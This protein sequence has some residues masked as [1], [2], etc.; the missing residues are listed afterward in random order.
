MKKNLLLS[1]SL[2]GLFTLSKL[3]KS[4]YAQVTVDESKN[5]LVGS[6]SPTSGYKFTV[7]GNSDVLGTI[8]SNEFL[9]QNLFGSI[10]MRQR[11]LSNP[12]L[13]YQ[14]L[15]IR[16][17]QSQAG[18]ISLTE[19]AVADRWTLGILPNQSKFVFSQGNPS[20]INDHF[21][22][23]RA[24]GITSI[25]L[26]NNL[27]ISSDRTVKFGNGSGN[28]NFK[29]LNN[30]NQDI[31]TVIDNGRVHIDGKFG[32]NS[33][34][35][36]TS[37]FTVGGNFKLYSTQPESD[38]GTN[39]DGGLLIAFQ[40]STNQTP[41]TQ[42]PCTRLYFGNGTGYQ[43]HFSKRVNSTTTDLMTIADDGTIVAGLLKVRPNGKVGINYNFN[44]IVSNFNVYGHFRLGGTQDD[45]DIGQTVETEMLI[46]NKNYDKRIFFGDGSGY[47]INF[48]KR[49]NTTTTDLV[50]I[51]DGGHMSI[52]GKLGIGITNPAFKLDIHDNAGTGTDVA[53]GTWVR[54]NN[55]DDGASNIGLATQGI[56]MSSIKGVKTSANNYNGFGTG[57]LQMNAFNGINSPGR[58]TLTSQGRVSIGYAN[59]DNI[60][61]IGLPSAVH[62]DLGIEIKSLNNEYGGGGLTHSYISGSGFQELSLKGRTDGTKISSKIAL[63]T[64][65]WNSG[66]SPGSILFYTSTAGS[67]EPVQRM[68]I[69]KEGDVY[70]NGATNGIIMKSPNGTCFKITID[71]NGNFYPAPLANCP[72]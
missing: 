27:K 59:P 58:M 35:N 51:S 9:T 12:T 13:Y 36:Y 14:E 61:H 44:P 5:V 7:N 45:A 71:D 16:P 39:V 50:T 40:N 2:I 65:G 19:N 4:L 15:H 25:S 56:I 34:N 62:S 52:V 43:M 8:R 28:N 68:Q 57:N 18:L 63:R 21:V 24:S 49:T 41:S 30:N 31:F 11:F 17:N 55:T 33:F 20:A 37:A 3:P 6:G 29:I 32:I 67:S 10:S 48:S 46:T 66:G 26:D 69:T 47:K 70:L 1:V 23:D 54:V 72:N 60:L 42:N 53:N 22:I 64:E 38:L